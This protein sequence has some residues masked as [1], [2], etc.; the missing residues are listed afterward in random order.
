M[1]GGLAAGALVAGLDFGPKP[2]FPSRL[3]AA[4]A[5]VGVCADPRPQRGRHPAQSA[6]SPQPPGSQHR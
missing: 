1:A 2:A 4:T 6:G 3:Y 5:A